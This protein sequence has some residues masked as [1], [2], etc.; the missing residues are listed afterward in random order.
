MTTTKTCLFA[1]SV[2]PKTKIQIFLD[3]LEDKSQ[4][5]LIRII[6]QLAYEVKSLRKR[7]KE[8]EEFQSL[9]GWRRNPGQGMH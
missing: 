1:D 3:S 9:E 4:G 6:H 7:N 8:L 2:M 5:E